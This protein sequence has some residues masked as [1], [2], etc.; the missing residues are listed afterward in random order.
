MRIFDKYIN[1]KNICTIDTNI[2]RYNAGLIINGTYVVLFQSAEPLEPVATRAAL[3]EDL[4]ESLRDLVD[5]E[6]QKCNRAMPISKKILDVIDK[7]K[8]GE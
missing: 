8:D 7:A 3:A 1:E 2:N 6:R 4:V 5:T